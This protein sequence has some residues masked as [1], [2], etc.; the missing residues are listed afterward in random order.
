M[1]LGIALSAVVLGLLTTG[2]VSLPSPPATPLEGLG[3]G[4]VIAP[5]L[6]YWQVRRVEPARQSVH[7]MRVELRRPGVTLMVTPGDRS[8]GM[9]Y[10]AQTPG[11]VL[12]GRKLTAVINGGYFLPFKGG[13]DHGDD[14]Y[15]HAGDPVN[16]TGLAI[17]DGR[18]D[19][20]VETGIDSRVNATLCIAGH[21]VWIRDGQ[22]C[23]ARVDHAMAAGP[24]LLAEGRARSYADADPDYGHARHPRTAVGLDARRGLMWLVVV[25]GRQPGL[26]DGATL[27]ELTTLFRDLGA[28][29]AINLDGGGSSEMAAIVNGRARVLNS[30]IHTRTPGRERPSANQLGVISR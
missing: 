4:Q 15:P 20:P 5:G 27:D 7:L 29:D 16:V 17:S 9:E 22:G 8:K 2:C 23:G 14:F 28:A 13:S 18:Q 10:V 12:L 26:S 1:R 6:T 25:D 30:P 3:A 19:S 21:R 24:R 11:A